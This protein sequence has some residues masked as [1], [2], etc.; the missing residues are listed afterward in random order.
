MTFLNELTIAHDGV[1]GRGVD[2]VADGEPRDG[3]GHD[4]QTQ[5][6][7]G[8]LDDRVDRHASGAL[9]GVGGRSVE[10]DLPL[11]RVV[12][13]RAA[14]AVELGA[15]GED[16]VAA[17]HGFPPWDGSEVES[18]SLPYPTLSTACLIPNHSL[19]A[20]TGCVG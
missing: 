5:R 14:A 15:A 12:G 13:D 10:V 9:L 11:G 3:G 17:L 16:R 20:A 19:G 4:E 18:L 1:A 8:L 2:D 7:A 6:H